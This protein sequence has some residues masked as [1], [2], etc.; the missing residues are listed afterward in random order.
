M[1]RGF[2]KD[3]PDGRG[4]AACVK[5]FAAYGQARRDEITIRRI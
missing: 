5:H 3:L 1:V 4:V 2:Q